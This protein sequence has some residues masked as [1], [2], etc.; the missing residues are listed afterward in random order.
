M[1]PFQA[2]LVNQENVRMEGKEAT[3]AGQRLGSSLAESGPPPPAVAAVT[4]A[5]A[6][7]L[8]AVAAYTGAG[9]G[10]KWHTKLPRAA[11][12]VRS[13]VTK[14]SNS[15]P[16]EGKKVFRINFSFKYLWNQIATYIRLIFFTDFCQTQGDLNSRFFLNSS[17]FHS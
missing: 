12:H 2:R 14:G 9:S 13:S 7:E 4:A 8:E 3:V 5:A 6:D 11:S 15:D 17:K 10:K 1:N 16:V